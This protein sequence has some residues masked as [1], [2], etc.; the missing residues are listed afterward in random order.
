MRFGMSRQHNSKIMR[1]KMAKEYEADGVEHKHDTNHM[2]YR[3]HEPSHGRHLHGGHSDHRGTHHHHHVTH[4][5]NHHY[6]GEVHIHNY[7]TE[8]SS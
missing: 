4:H 6:H 1:D 2:E 7:D 5:H 3:E 8:E